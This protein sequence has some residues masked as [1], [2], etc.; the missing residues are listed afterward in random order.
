MDVKALLFAGLAAML[1]VYAAALFRGGF[2]V[3]TAL[4]AGIGFVTAFF[5][6]LGIGSF[7]TTTAIYKL[8]RMVLIGIR[9]AHEPIMIGKAA[10]GFMPSR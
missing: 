10:V 8:R 6:T 2:V 3:P 7:A 5:D 9:N 1:V 4:Q